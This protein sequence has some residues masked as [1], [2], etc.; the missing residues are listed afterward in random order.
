MKRKSENNGMNTVKKTSFSALVRNGGELAEL[1]RD[2]ASRSAKERRNAADWEYHSQMATEIFN[3]AVLQSGKEGLGESSWPAGYVALAM[4]PL[5]APAILTVG[6]V[7][8]QL[9]RKAEAMELFKGLTEL[10]KNEEDLHIVIDKAGDFLHLNDLG[11]SLLEAGKLD[12]AEEVLKRAVSLAPAD[13]EF[14]RNNLNYL[15]EKKKE[16]GRK[17]DSPKAGAVRG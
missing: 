8:Y 13:Y 3:G 17:N 16:T 15:A 9:G 7:E 12:E 1:R 14:P 4:D 11:F 2:Y 6:S 5:Y 10:P